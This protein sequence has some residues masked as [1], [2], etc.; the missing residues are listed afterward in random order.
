MRVRFEVFRATFKSWNDLC[1][2]AA[3]FA[4][5]RGSDRVIN[6]SVSEDHGEGVIIVWYWE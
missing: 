1:E 2:Q 6:I 4:S 5:Q 3:E